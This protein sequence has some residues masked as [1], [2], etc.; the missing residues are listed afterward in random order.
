MPY[1]DPTQDSIQ[2]FLAR[3][4]EGPVDMLN[5]LRFRDV[6]DYSAS[7]ELAPPGS[8]SGVAAYDRYIAHTLPFLNA[9]GATVLY[10]GAGGGALIGPG[11]ESW[12]RVLVVRHKSVAAFLSFARDPAYLAGAG[13]RSA[14]LADSR[15]VP[16]VGA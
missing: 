10:D 12:D 6:A 9:A 2:A 4:I 1:T 5:L 13:H 14:A 11:D 15:L 16:M 3:G 8:I 7:P